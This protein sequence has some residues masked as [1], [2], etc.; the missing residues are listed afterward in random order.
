MSA[1]RMSMPMSE[2]VDLRVDRTIPFNMDEKAIV[3]TLCYDKTL[4]DEDIVSG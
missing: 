3:I 2:I 1:D 4:Y